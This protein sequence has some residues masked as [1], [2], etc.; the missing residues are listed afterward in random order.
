[1]KKNKIVNVLKTDSYLSELMKTDGG[2]IPNSTLSVLNELLDCFNRGDE[3]Y[4]AIVETIAD[5]KN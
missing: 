1:M 3:E 2:Y 4:I 5:L